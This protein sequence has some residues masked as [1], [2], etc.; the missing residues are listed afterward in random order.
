MASDLGRPDATF[1]E[2]LEELR[3]A[4]SGERK[5]AAIARAATQ[6]PYVQAMLE[7]KMGLQK[8]LPKN[9][10]NERIAEIAAQ[11]NADLDDIFIRSSKKD[12]AHIKKV[13]RQARA[14]IEA[15]RPQEKAP[16]APE[17]PETAEEAEPVIDDFLSFVGQEEA[18]AIRQREEEVQ[19][20]AQDA[21]AVQGEFGFDKGKVVKGQV[22][23]RP[24]LIP[25]VRAVLARSTKGKWTPKKVAQ[26]LVDQPELFKN[27]HNMIPEVEE[28]MRADET[29]GMF[30]GMGGFVE[31]P[32]ILEDF[33]EKAIQTADNHVENITALKKMLQIMFKQGGAYIAQFG[34]DGQLISDDI[35][36]IVRIV[37]RLVE[38]DT[39]E[40]NDI[41]RGL[42]RRERRIVGM[43]VNNRID[44]TVV[45][46]RLLDKA[47]QL[48]AVLDR[49]MKEAAGLG[50]KR[51]VNGKLVLLSGIGHAMPHVLNRQ[52]NKAVKKAKSGKGRSDPKIFAWAQEQKDKGLYD[53]IDEA[54]LDLGH[55]ND[56]IMNGSNP[57]F[58]STRGTIPT[59]WIEWD[60]AR[61]LPA[62]VERNWTTIEAVR[63]WGY[64]QEVEEG[65]FDDIKLTK[66]KQL[67]FPKLNTRLKRIQF[68]Y[69]PSEYKRVK[70]F[71]E[72]AF[73]I[74]DHAPRYQKVLSKHTRAFQFVTKI[75]LSPLGI[76]RNILDRLPMGMMVS[77]TAFIQASVEY[78]PFINGLIKSSRD[79]D[80]RIRRGGAVFGHGTLTEGAGSGNRIDDILT[81]PFS[82]SERGNQVFIGR[83][84]ELKLQRDLALLEKRLADKDKPSTRIN[85]GIRAVFGQG[86]KAVRWRLGKR[87]AAKV[88]AGEN[89]TQED[90]Y[91]FM[92]EMVRDK[93]HPKTLATKEIWYDNSPF[94][95]IAWQF[96]TWSIERSK[97]LGREVVAY[98]AKTGDFS[99][100]L[101][102]MVATIIAGEV[103]NLARDLLRGTANSMIMQA[104]EDDK[105]LG[106]ALLGDLV[107]GGGIGILADLT[108]GIKD[109]VAGVSARTGTNVL[110]AVRHG[111]KSPRLIP[112]ATTKLISQEYTTARQINDTINR[113]HDAK[114]KQGRASQH[115]R[116]RNKAWAW[117]EGEEQSGV[118]GYITKTAEEAVIGKESYGIGENTLAY[119]MIA[120]N[121]V[122]GDPKDAAGF[123]AYLLGRSEDPKKTMASIKKSRASKA[124]LGPIARKDWP[125][126]LRS[127]SPGGKAEAIEAQKR[128][129]RTYGEALKQGVA[130]WRARK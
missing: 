73:G 76:A 29:G 93:A 59:D 14:E 18:E 34:E 64:E 50:I 91:Q 103:Y 126:F 5:N 78:P 16:D 62:L 92:H 118:W 35:N 44:K 55:M 79:L 102:F 87:L 30:P 39:G 43:A 83:V 112:E 106:K 45:P 101:N 51:L 10:I 97:F 99:R 20:R 48:Q 42:N 32:E 6:D 70:E 129:L 125:L 63:K 15:S 111:V 36:E 23:I 40:I 122:A 114:D 26:E 33:K 110:T 52:G 12:E 19:Q 13:L 72:T 28:A 81:A 107:D 119:E 22:P 128:Y 88:E 11:Y 90:M 41:Y 115:I 25:A 67:E 24:E 56:D 53:N 47:K 58:T 98:T 85:R 31:T 84:H 105:E 7:K 17:V 8:G 4:V 80:K 2:F 127:L 77:P 95:Q 121:V 66:Q 100:L 71:L 3:D 68:K 1:D 82:S 113:Y 74:Q 60:G 57:Y 65:L 38:R 94:M 27:P 37:T 96:K 75:G 54:I 104:G 49:S 86:E 9:D 61:T 130:M 116:T 109:W 89:I 120:R 123:V 69:G 124:P 108:Y 117:K 21:V 46:Q